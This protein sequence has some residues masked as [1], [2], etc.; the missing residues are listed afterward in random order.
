[1]TAAGSN[2]PS[3]TRRANWRTKAGLALFILSIGWVIVIPVMPMLGFSTSAIAAFSGVMAVVAELLL[4]AAVAVAGKE[5]FVNIK[6]S[7]FGWIKSYGPPQKVSRAR[8]ATGLLLFILPLLFA[9]A[10]PYA[11]HFFPGLGEQTLAV[12]IIGDALLLIALFVLGGDFWDKLRSLFVHDA[13]AL[14]P[15]ATATHD[16]LGR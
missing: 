16:R 10:S 8:Y 15:E 4:L 5:G 13:S 14:F 7:A 2:D 11:V 1:M 3:V 6:R 9:W 12:A